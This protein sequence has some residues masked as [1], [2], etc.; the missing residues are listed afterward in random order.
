MNRLPDCVVVLEIQQRPD[1]LAVHGNRTVPIFEHLY[2]QSPST[3]RLNQSGQALELTRLSEFR[4]GRKIQWFHL[5][6]LENKKPAA[7]CRGL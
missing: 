2:S 6:S 3:F 7:A 4:R 5:S 1:S